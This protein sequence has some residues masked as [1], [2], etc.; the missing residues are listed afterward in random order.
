VSARLTGALPVFAGAT[1]ADALHGGDDY[2][3]LFTTPP[4]ARVPKVV[5]GLPLTC[6][7]EVRAGNAGRVFLGDEELAP[8]GWDHFVS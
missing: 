2:E 7:G 6:I 8:A 5:A 1:E 4:S 3:L